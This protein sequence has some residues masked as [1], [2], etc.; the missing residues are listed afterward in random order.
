MS[1]LHRDLRLAWRGFRRTPLFLAGIVLTLAVGVGANSA[2]FSILHAVLLQPLPYRDPDR[3]VMVW[4]SGAQPANWRRGTTA[5][6]IA[7]W[8]DESKEVLEDLAAFKLWAGNLEAQI[9]L[10]TTAGAERL[11]GALVTPNF[12]S[13]LGVTAATGRV[14]TEDDEAAGARDLAVLSHGLWQRAF[15]GDAQIAGRSVTFMTGRSPRGPRALTIVGVLPP[16][17]RFTYPRDTELWVLQPWSEIRNDAVRAIS[18]NGAVGRLR[19]AVTFD[20]AQARMISAG[21][22]ADEAARPVEQRS[23]TRLERA[24]DWVTAETRPSLLLLGGVA[25]LLLLITCATVATALFIRQVANRR[26]LSVRAAL[27]ANRSQL[28]RHALSEGVILVVLG[29]V[30]GIVLSI[31]LHPVLRAIVPPIVPRADEIGLTI[32]VVIFAIVI[33]GV[34]VLLSAFAPAWRAGRTDVSATLGRGAGVSSADRSSA[35]WRSA[36]LATESAVAAALL[37]SAGLLLTSFWR[38]NR[39]DLGFDGDKVLTVEIRLLDMRYRKPGAIAAFQNDLLDRVRAVPG[40]VEAG[41]TS[42]V[43]FRGVDFTMSLDRPGQKGRHTAN[44]RYVDA[45][46][47]SVMK[48]PLKSGRMFTE[49]DTAATTK[50]MLVSESFAKRVFGTASPIGQLIDSDEPTTIVG[51]V[52]DVRYVGSELEAAPAVYY[53]R[54]QHPRELVCIVAR[55]APGAGDLGPAVRGAIADLDPA[56]PAMDLTTIDRI[57]SE[58]VADRRFT[59][60]AIT[61]F[62]GVALVLTVAGIAAVVGRTVVERRRELAIRS[63]LGATRRHLA[64]LVMQQGLGPTAAGTMIGLC[65][66]FAASTLLDRFLFGVTPREPAVYL[67]VAGLILCVT[68]LASLVPGRRASRAAPAS[69]LRTE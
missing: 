3:V 21:V 45:A 17:F 64:R 37:V 40:V 41:L 62:A 44:G 24:A 12:F 56:I 4:N 61:A 20:Q 42:A 49:T 54:T 60:T 48:I 11:R 52:G 5:Q 1:A 47:F 31:L 29:S 22:P 39:V 36:L 2:V 38:L 34:T 50:V 32:P 65:A 26:E 66:A 15:G 57:V 16:S 58:S 28:V 43:P 63:A 9:D 33:T 51:V 67:A 10:I 14:F 27:G 25:A 7:A 69:L 13:T 55:T 8:H 53:P 35:R 23:I 30:T 59:V 18:H 68:L 19:P 6:R 46:Y